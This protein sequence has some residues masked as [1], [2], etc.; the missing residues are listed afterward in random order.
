MSTEVEVSRPHHKGRPRPDEETPGLRAAETRRDAVSEGRHVPYAHGS[1]AAAD[2]RPRV[3]VRA[4]STLGAGRDPAT[5]GVRPMSRS[6][7]TGL[8]VVGDDAASW[9]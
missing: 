2:R 4:R 6:P 3:A 7:C 5:S 9:E 1:P 8:S